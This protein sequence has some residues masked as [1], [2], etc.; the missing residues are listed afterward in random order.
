MR[1][2]QLTKPEPELDQAEMLAIYDEH[3][4]QAWDTGLDVK[5]PTAQGPFWQP[6][7]KGCRAWLQGRGHTL[8]GTCWLPRA[9][10]T[11]ALVSSC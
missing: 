7:T 4:L 6:T 10:Q 11:V 1:V 8:V 5:S 2:P 9:G 3:I